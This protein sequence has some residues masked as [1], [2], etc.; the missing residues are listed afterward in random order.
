MA[1][2]LF[3][4]RENRSNIRASWRAPEKTP[5]G[6]RWRDYVIERGAGTADGAARFLETATS[7]GALAGKESAPI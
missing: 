5:R 3:A 7:I 6:P 1:H 4:S 2:E